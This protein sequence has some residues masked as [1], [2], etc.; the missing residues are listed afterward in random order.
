[1]SL[2]ENVKLYVWLTVMASI[3]FPLLGAL[4]KR[5][6][7]LDMVQEEVLQEFRKDDEQSETLRR[8]GVP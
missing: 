2:V 4:L 6:R 3:V 8:W 1:M 5:L 7:N